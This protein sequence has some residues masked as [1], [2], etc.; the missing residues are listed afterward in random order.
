MVAI[1]FHLPLDCVEDTQLKTPENMT[2]A[3]FSQDASG[4]VPPPIHTANSL[5]VEITVHLSV[6]ET[7]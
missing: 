7:D 1:H 2:K 3:G 5:F 6:A 4:P